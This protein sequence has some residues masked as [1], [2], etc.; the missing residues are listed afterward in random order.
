MKVVGLLSGGK[1][2]CYNLCH[3]LKNGHQLVALATL[4]PGP[5]KDELDSYLYQT[6]GQ[7]G[8]HLV[9][10]A[11]DVPLYRRTITGTA[12]ELK[13][14]Y[15]SRAY[16]SQMVGVT[17]DETE[18]MYQLLCEVKRLHPEIK[19]LSVGAILSNYQR[20]RVEHVAQRLG[21]VPLAYL[22]QRDQSELLQ[23]MVQSGLESIL[24]KVASIGLEPKHLGKSLSQMQHKLEELNSKYGVHVCG[25]GGEYETFTVDCPIFKTRINLTQTQ[26]VDHPESSPMAPVA[27][28]RLSSATLSPKPGWTG[29]EALEN[30]MTPPIFDDESQTT[31]QAL[32]K[33][34]QSRSSDSISTKSAVAFL[35]TEP[36][37]TE[38]RGWVAVT[39]V[40]APGLVIKPPVPYES[41]EKEVSAAFDT[42]T[43][44]LD[45]KY[46]RLTDV[47]HINLFLRCMEDFF[48]V[49]E[50]YKTRFGILPPT[51]ACIATQ[52][53][54]CSRL[55]LEAIARRG[56]DG[57]NSKRSGLH[58]QSRSYWAP[59]NIGPYSQ[60]I[61][62]GAKIFIAGQIGLIP[63]SL[64][65][66][67]PTSLIQEAVLSLQHVRRILAT[68]QST[69]WIEGL[70]C[71]IT[72]PAHLDL[73]RASWRETSGIYDERIPILFLVVDELPKGA[74]I[75]WQVV[76]S[77]GTRLPVH[78]E[79]ESDDADD[80][81]KLGPVYSH[82]LGSYQ[83]CISTNSRMV[84][85]MGC[86]RTPFM[87]NVEFD[88]VHV[89]I[90]HLPN[91]T[92]SEARKMVRNC[93]PS[94]TVIEESKCGFSTVCVKS[95]ELG[96]C[97]AEGS[98]NTEKHEIEVG[99]WIMGC[100]K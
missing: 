5:D 87:G 12:L 37:V 78:D 60:A 13:S 1:D 59:A 51:R 65:L 91:T 70:V 64:S 34:P 62:T 67:K 11:L 26:V 53:P 36:Q 50:V 89:R 45:S 24:I 49:N 52:L 96:S 41:L 69:S 79:R 68:F 82:G 29:P 93:I 32:G 23:E 95:I 77:D 7:D 18:D 2:S 31:L 56:N 71:F 98:C 46:L 61:N 22:W 28:L 58:V 88:P 25:E 92:A 94:L 85:M 16:Q 27:Y 14:E 6:V 54:Q 42:L 33:L 19:A 99:F 80:T 63:S 76:A 4:G 38:C 9:A 83:A 3:C 97:A 35:P 21:L 81:Y 44:S 100:L 74:L 75:E 40:V 8:V 43:T 84:T 73:A 57:I 10:E 66:P 30:V 17:G 39:S 15:G 48:E 90:F 20:V 47:A 72:D 86:T 55:M